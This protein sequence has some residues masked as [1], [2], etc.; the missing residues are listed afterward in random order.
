MQA[1]GIK[2][3]KKLGLQDSIDFSVDSED[4]NFYAEGI[5]TSNCYSYAYI[6]C[7]TTY[8]KAT[9]PLEFFLAILKLAQFEAKPMPVINSV[10]KE[11]KFFGFELLPPNIHKSQ[12]DYCIDGKTI[13]TGLSG[14]KGISEKALDKL[15]M[16]KK[17]NAN[18]FE[19]FESIQQAKLPINIMRAL[20]M[21]GCIETFGATRSKLIL[22]LEIYALLTDKEKLIVH[23]LGKDNNWNLAEIIVAC[24]KTHKN[25]KGVAL[26]KDSR[27][28]TLRRDYAPYWEKYKQNTKHEKLSSFIMES[29]YLGYSYSTTLKNI[30]S[31]FCQDLQTINEIEGELNN[32]NVRFAAQVVESENKISRAKKTPYVRVLLKDETGEI[33][34][35]KFGQEQIEEMNSFNGKQIE[36]GDIVIVNG[37]KN[38]EIIFINSLSIQDNPVVIKKS[39]LKKQKEA[40]L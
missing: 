11:M 23:K 14:I 1:Q 34:A 2:S 26:I 7:Y 33:V 18:K 15:R 39:D 13:L 40:V 35:M 16:F 36:E 29:E 22:E 24:N 38:N 19:L 20:I 17:D 37:K 28:E 27:I 9:K 6:T 8:L 3:I 21:S 5:V 4:H 32:E 25:E 30:Y 31:D 12:A 10:Q